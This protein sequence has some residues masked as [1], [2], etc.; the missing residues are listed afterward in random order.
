MLAFTDWD[1][2]ALNKAAR[3]KLQAAGQ[4]GSESQIETQ[5]GVRPIAVG[6]HIRFLKGNTELGVKYGTTGTVQAI[7]DGKLVVDIDSPD[8]DKRRVTIDPATFKNFDYG[9][10]TTTFH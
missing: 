10:A 5:S 1:A 3:S 9:Y 4:L 8:A 7:N 6:E 2:Q